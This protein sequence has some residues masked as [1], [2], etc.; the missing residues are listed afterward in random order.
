[1]A[2]VLE[3]MNEFEWYPKKIYPT[4]EQAE[5]AKK[6][7]EAK[8]QKWAKSQPKG[9]IFRDMPAIRLGE[10]AYRIKKVKAR[11]LEAVV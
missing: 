2:F 11:K 1:M 6:R 8:Y 5:E 4:K 10:M 7:Y 9:S 3:E